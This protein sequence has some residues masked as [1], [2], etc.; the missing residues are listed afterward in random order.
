MRAL[1]LLA[2]AA[3]LAG[4]Q[5]AGGIAGG[6][7]GVTTGAVTAN[8][9]VGYAVAAGVEAATDAAVKYVSRNMQRGEQ[10]AISQTA[11]TLPL[12]VAADW[13]IEHAL[14]F[15]YGDAEGRV[16]P[17]REIPNPLTPC[18]EV[19]VTVKGAP[20]HFITSI[21]KARDGWRWAAAEPA[22]ARWGALQ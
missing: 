15:G 6:I 7:A 14:P 4:C 19:V 3:G 20:E 17:V 10:D 18:R 13:K 21:C 16:R 1:A 11:G 5:A 8:P 12:G 2:A 22:V 9:A